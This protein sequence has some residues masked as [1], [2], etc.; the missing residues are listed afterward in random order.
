[1]SASAQTQSAL[2]KR[3]SSVLGSRLVEELS[4]LATFDPQRDVPD[5]QRDAVEKISDRLTE[6]DGPRSGC[7]R[8]ASARVH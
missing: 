3:V 1:M 6:H 7:S 2:G 5:E 4:V 8:I